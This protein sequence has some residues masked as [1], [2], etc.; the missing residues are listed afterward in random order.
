MPTTPTELQSICSQFNTFYGLN[1]TLAEL[2]PGNVNSADP[3]PAIN[4]MTTTGTPLLTTDSFVVGTDSGNLG[5]FA[6]VEMD[7]AV[8]AQNCVANNIAYGSVRNI[9]DPVQ[10]STLTAKIQAHWGQAIYDAY[11]F[12]TS[13]NGAIAAW[14]IVHG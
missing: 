4:N 13:Y 7:D 12:Y 11:G 6:C 1:Q 3:Q 9:S 14:A 5:A 10:N 2:N 8:I